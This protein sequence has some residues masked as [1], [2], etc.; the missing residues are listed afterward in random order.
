MHS[1]CI[2]FHHHSLVLVEKGV[3]VWVAAIASILTSLPQPVAA[4]PSLLFVTH[5]E[6]IL[7]AGLGFAAGA[8]GRACIV[9]VSLVACCV[10]VRHRL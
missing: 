8:C 9:Y 2:P 6:P 5:F 1:S 4:V 10:V 7:P 3:S